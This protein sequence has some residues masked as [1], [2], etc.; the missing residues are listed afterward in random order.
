M[1]IGYDFADLEAFLAVL[2]T[3]SFHGAAGRLGLSQPAVTRRVQK[4]ETALGARLF[5]RGTRSVR[6]TLAGKRLRERAEGMLNEARETARA[7]RGESAAHAR[8]RVRTVTLAAVPTAVPGLVAPAIRALLSAEPRAR[9]RVIDRAANEVAEAVAGGEAD[10]GLCSIPLLEP[11]A[12]FEPLA[13]DPIDLALPE[14]HPLAGRGALSWADLAGERL[15]LPARGTGNRLL[16]DEALARARIEAPWTVE[17][18]RTSTA[19]ALVAAGLGAAPVPRAAGGAPACVLRPIGAPEVSRSLGL[20]RR[21]GR[22]G[23]PQAE[24][25]AAA[26]RAA[27]AYSSSS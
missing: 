16:I 6:P 4:L 14:G 1:R 21:A 26:I 27:A 10:L 8:A 24:A 13:D 15:I 25:L 3:G 20:L 11:G 12:T 9:V 5:E 17:A 2:S 19:L 7:M 18:R 22:A 23:A